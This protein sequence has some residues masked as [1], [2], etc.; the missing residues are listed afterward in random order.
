MPPIHVTGP[1]RPDPG[2]RGRKARPLNRLPAL[3]FKAASGAGWESVAGLVAGLK[4]YAWL[5]PRRNRREIWRCRSAFDHLGGSRG[6]HRSRRWRFRCSHLRA[7]GGLRCDV[8][9]RIAFSGVDLGE[10]FEPRGAAP[11]PPF[12]VLLEEDGADQTDA[13][14]LGGGRRRGRRRGAWPPWR[15]A[16]AG[17]RCAAWR[18]PGPGSPCRRARR[19]RS[20]PSASRAWASGR[21]AGRRRGARSRRRSC[22]RAG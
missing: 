1:I 21:G 19:L 5:A 18:G 6:S 3:R 10:G 13:A 2:P 15:G 17:L 14:V 8:G 9:K 12:V 7:S 20:R 16:R 11:A 4:A 22:C